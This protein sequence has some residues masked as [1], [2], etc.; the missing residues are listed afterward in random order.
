VAQQLSQGRWSAIEKP[1]LLVGEIARTAGIGRNVSLD[2]AVTT[3]M[4]RLIRI[5]DTL[6]G[7]TGLVAKTVSFAEL[8][9]FDPTVSALAFDAKKAQNVVALD[10]LDF[11][12]AGSA[13]ALEKERAREVP[14][15]VAML[16]LC[17]RK[18]LLL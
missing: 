14:L 5:P 13:Y 12:F 2:R 7:D 9:S 4:S 3:D 1:E 10:H 16:L 8:A 11:F 15:P 17:K 6:H 18:A